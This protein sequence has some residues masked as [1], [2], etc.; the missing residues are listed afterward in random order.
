MPLG[1][2]LAHALAETPAAALIA[3][4]ERAHQAARL[5]AAVLGEMQPTASA[6]P[7]LDCRIREHEL[8]V[9]ASSVAQ[10]A[11]IRQSLPRLLKA[12]QERGLNLSEIRVRVQPD[13]SAEAPIPDRSAAGDRNARN[14]GRLRPNQACALCFADELARELRA[15]PLRDAAARLAGRLRREPTT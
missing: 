7:T 2:T 3:R 5:I 13:P 10:A 11:K 1:K 12:L 9:L 8:L 4:C 6:S 15:S 14:P